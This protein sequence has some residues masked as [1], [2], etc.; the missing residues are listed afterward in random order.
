MS[1]QNQSVEKKLHKPS[2]AKRQLSLFA[3]AFRPFFLAGSAAAVILMIFWLLS[4]TGHIGPTSYLD[5][6]IWH[7]HEM[8]FG[9]AAAVIVGFLLTAVQTWTGIPSVKGNALVLLFLL[10]F[11][12]RLLLAF[13]VEDIQLLTIFIDL[14][15]FPVV[16][17]ILAAKVIRT[18]QWHNGIFLPVL[19]LFFIANLLVHLQALGRGSAA[20]TGLALG[21]WLVLLLI[22][23]IG[24]RVLP[25]FTS[26][27]LGG[28]KVHSYKYINI[29]SILFFILLAASDLFQ[30]KGITPWLA[31]IC[32]IFHSIRL[33]GLRPHLTVKTPLLW[34]LH[35]GYAWLIIGLILFGLSDI[36]SLP[37]SVAIHAFA[38]GTVGNF[39]IGMMSRVSLG[40]TGRPLQPAKIMT[41]AFGLINIATVA[42]V[43]LP[44]FTPT[45]WSIF[46][47]AAG[48]FWILAY[49]IF[50]LV[51]L[52]ILSKPRVDGKE[53]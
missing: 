37:R 6:V 45:Q 28:I 1:D 51:Y 36:L 46:I 53:G 25:M 8:I 13:P 44:L 4:L 31:G 41:L 52:P 3:L 18:K 10:W 27:G 38:V 39:I 15:F 5:P 47:V 50:F 49:S 22:I 32:V 2:T 7:S 35:I 23:I 19:T 17:V 26:N 34:V 48:V 42:R 29:G 21:L 9:F 24:G 33:Y 12:G 20:D 30:L 40:H 43:F 14:L 16:A 11:M